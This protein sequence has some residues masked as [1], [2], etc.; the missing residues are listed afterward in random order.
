MTMRAGRILIY[1]INYAPEE[2]G[3]GKY[4]SELSEYLAGRGYEVEIVTA[5]PHYPGWA[6]RDGFQNRYSVEQAGAIRITRCPL[7]LRQKM[8]GV[9]RLLSPLS[10]AMSSAPV[11][12]SRIL[13][14]RPDVV[15]C[16]EPTLLV[17]PIALIAAKLVGARTV[18]HVQDLEVEAAF[19]VGHLRSKLLHKMARWFERSLLRAFDHVITISDK[20]ALKLID[21]GVSPLKISRLRNWVDIGAIKP[22]NGP[23][24]FRDEL[25]IR[26]DDFVALYAGNLGAKQ[27][28][29]VV[30]A[31]AKRLLNTCSKVRFVIAGEGP[32]KEQMVEQSLNNV[33]FLPV[34]PKEKLCELLNLADLH[35]LPQSSDISDLVMPS[36]LGGM[37]ASGKPVLVT[38]NPDTEL[39]DFL[40]GSAVIV[41]AGDDEA[42][43]REIAR[44]AENGSGPCAENGLVAQFDKDVILPQFA[45]CLFDWREPNSASNLL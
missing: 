18:I 31:T 28:L 10:F 32:L 17:A 38:A 44:C 22:L 29:H 3:V 42:M 2:I 21:G 27:G 34:Q 43:A 37:L 20:M 1:G 24:V 25:G 5:T 23:N 6:T 8:R 15:L 39:Y 33:S 4:T 14:T 45:A 36:K 35:L 40:L 13:T 7:F 26:A 41:P 9:W 11:S 12:V 19:G 16:V 30:M